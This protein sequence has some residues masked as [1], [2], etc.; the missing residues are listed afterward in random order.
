MLVTKDSSVRDGGA[1]AGQQEHTE[2]EARHSL[3]QSLTESLTHS[4]STENVGTRAVGCQFMFQTVPYSGCK[5]WRAVPAGGMHCRG[6][7][8][9]RKLFVNGYQ[10]PR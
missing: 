9:F 10:C 6:D 2:G 8:L 3:I 5:G 4:F 7:S 1:E